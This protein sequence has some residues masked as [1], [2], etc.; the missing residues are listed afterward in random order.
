MFR[1][2]NLSG[3]ILAFTVVLII[4]KKLNQWRRKQ[5]KSDKQE[6]RSCGYICI[7]RERGCGHNLTIF[8]NDHYH[9]YPHETSTKGFY[10]L[11]LHLSL[12]KFINQ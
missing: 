2:G 5:I 10:G 3:Y 12:K 9:H 4:H 1:T 6:K 11:F 8:F 7:T